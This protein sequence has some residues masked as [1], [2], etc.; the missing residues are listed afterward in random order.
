MAIV[1]VGKL[2]DHSEIARRQIW[3]A[4]KRTSNPGRGELKLGDRRQTHWAKI[5]GKFGALQQ[6]LSPREMQ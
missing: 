2:H 6:S 1:F 4:L 5:F 3:K